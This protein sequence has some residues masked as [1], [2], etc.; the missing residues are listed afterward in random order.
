MFQED[1]MNRL[2]QSATPLMSKSLDLGNL[3]FTDDSQCLNDTQN[4]E[5]IDR[6]VSD[7]AS[8]ASS[9]FGFQGKW[10]QSELGDATLDDM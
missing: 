3:L 7:L 4:L 6:I 9:F 2:V 10:G 1:F 5:L 8:I